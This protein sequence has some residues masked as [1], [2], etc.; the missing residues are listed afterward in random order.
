M[1]M[2]A[3]ANPFGHSCLIFSSQHHEHAP[4]RAINSFGYYSQANSSTNPVVSFIK[5][6]IGL[7]VDLQDGHGVLKQEDMRFLAG[8]GLKAIS[9]EVSNQ[10]F[11]QILQSISTI[12]Q[13]EE[14]AINDAN[15]ALEQLNQS[16]NGVTRLNHEQALA[17]REGRPSR[18][19]KF[20]LTLD[21]YF[22]TAQ[23]YTC[24]TR[25]IDILGQHEVI[26]HQQVSLLKGEGFS[27]AFPRSST[28]GLNQLR[29]V[30]CGRRHLSSNGLFFNHYWNKNSLYWATP[31]IQ[32]QQK[33]NDDEKINAQTTY[34]RLDTCLKQKDELTRKLYQA[35][36][37]TQ[38]EWRKLQLEGVIEQLE[39]ASY[40]LYRIERNQDP[41]QL[42]QTTRDLQKLINYSRF[43]FRL[44]QADSLLNRFSEHYTSKIM[45]GL[46]TTVG[47]LAFLAPSS[48]F[49]V[50]TLFLAAY[51]SYPF[52]Q[53]EQVLHFMKQDYLEVKRR[54][55]PEPENLS[56]LFN[57]ENQLQL[58]N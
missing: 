27:S 48:W 54:I 8:A 13:E 16:K 43:I 47:V 34:R 18:L 20:H 28:V 4:I 53:N 45:L 46:I 50:I 21:Q 17:R 44:P 3:G 38:S 56:E 24:K 37:T 55:E 52:Y 9:F 36:Q 32:F 35:R 49:L 25:A 29:T 42:E 1:D 41:Q 33:L 15:R 7:N 39:N 11:V 2:D 30:S 22:S 58:L 57:E 12:I 26:D 5:R 23:S 31:L 14:Q 6:M 40:Q 51:T 19:N 10:K